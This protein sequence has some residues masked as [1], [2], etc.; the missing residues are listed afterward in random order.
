[1]RMISSHQWL[2]LTANPKENS[3]TKVFFIL[4]VCSGLL[5]LYWSAQGPIT[6]ARAKV[7]ELRTLN[8]FNLGF[9]RGRQY[10]QIW[11]QLQLKKKK[12]IISNKERGPHVVVLHSRLCF[13]SPLHP[14]PRHPIM[15]RGENGTP[16]VMAHLLFLWTNV[17][18]VTVPH[19]LSSAPT[20]ISSHRSVS[21][22][23]PLDAT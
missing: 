8:N 14:P 7:R 18:M 11:H 5:L 3:S 2:T 6:Q 21:S 1:M 20:F 19:S 22:S 9:L 10:I 17:S 15:R 13:H 12:K 23:P 4:S 16:V